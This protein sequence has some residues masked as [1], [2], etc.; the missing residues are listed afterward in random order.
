MCE[1]RGWKGRDTEI[2]EGLADWSVDKNSTSRFGR[3]LLLGILIVAALTR[4]TNMDDMVL[5][6]YL[7]LIACI[8]VA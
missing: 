3:D 1:T 2:L 8:V 4:V 5:M 7:R 6:A